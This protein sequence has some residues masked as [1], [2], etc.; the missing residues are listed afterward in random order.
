MTMSA[1]NWHTTLAPESALTTNPVRQRTLKLKCTSP[2]TRLGGALMFSRKRITKVSPDVTLLESSILSP[3][4]TLTRRRMLT[5][6]TSISP[7]KMSLLMKVYFNPATGVV[8]RGLSDPAKRMLYFCRN[9]GSE[10]IPVRLVALVPLNK[11]ECQLLSF[12]RG[13]PNKVPHVDTYKFDDRVTL[14]DWYL[15][16]LIRSAVPA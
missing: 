8:R 9:V 11:S 1:Q 15:N 10:D 16:L 3:R 12:S 2:S 7:V 13:I 4:P 6:I 5:N 14:P